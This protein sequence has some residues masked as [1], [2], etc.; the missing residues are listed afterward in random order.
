MKHDFFVCVSIIVYR[1]KFSDLLGCL[2]KIDLFVKIPINNSKLIYNLLAFLYT[3]DNFIIIKWPWCFYEKFFFVM[4]TNSRAPEFVREC[5]DE[6]MGMQ[7]SLISNWLTTSLPPQTQ[8]SDK[9][10]K[11]VLVK[12]SIGSIPHIGSGIQMKSV[13]KI[14]FLYLFQVRLSKSLWGASQD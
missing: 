2:L 1:R 9:K 13:I 3:F 11:I 10:G 8:T 5:G 4:H 14:C 6:K 12:S 7:S